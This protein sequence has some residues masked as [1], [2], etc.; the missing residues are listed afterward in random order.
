MP[1]RTLPPQLINQI[2]AGEVVERPASAVKELVENALDAHATRVEVDVE[3]GG[4]RL[5]RIRDD[6]TGIPRDELPL[7]LSRHATSKIS[8][9]DELERVATLGFRG[10]AL[11]SISSISRLLLTSRTRGDE[12][13]WQVA[14]DGSETG[15]DLRP[16]AHPEGTTIEVRD[17]FYNTPARRKF[18]R[19][20]KT[21][22]QHIETLIK[23]LALARFTVGFALTHN[24]RSVL[25]IRP[26][27]HQTDIDDRLSAL[28]GE[29]FLEQSMPVEFNAAGLRLSGWVGLPTY[30]RSQAD[31]QYFYVNGRLVRDKLVSVAI[32]QAY[33]D[34]LYH[35]RQP[36]YVLYL[37]LDP[38][39]VD[40]NAHPTKM[41]VRFRETR[42][43][44]DFLFSGLHRTLGGAKAGLALAVSEIPIMGEAGPAS[45]PMADSSQP[46]A[47]GPARGRPA[48]GYRQ[49][50]L[51]LNVAELMK[52]YD[53]LYAPSAAASTQAAIASTTDVPVTD[54][55][56]GV[57]PPLGYALAH[58]HGAFILAESSHGLIIVD[59]HAAH[60]RITYE[61]L[62]RQQQ[63][64]PVPSQLLL[65]PMRLKVSEAEAELAEESAETLA[66]LGIDIGRIS[67]DTLVV[68]SLPVLLCQSNAEPLLRDVLADISQQGHSRR[69]EE[70]LNQIL[71]TMACHGAVRAHRKL[72]MPEMNGLLRELEVTER[73][74]QCNHGRP[75]WVALSLT[76]LNALFL[77]G[78]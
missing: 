78:R 35:G 8:S 47:A 33:Q 34:V 53:G 55:P 32:R 26:A 49:P 75:T 40:V 18:L 46:A 20:E 42:V 41:E 37:E 23:R 51:P 5:L 59:A 9:L 61:K 50:Q 27:L 38:S 28:L 19:S 70:R 73:S 58:L 6:G 11:P 3:Q 36:V 52:A 67:P 56:E 77:R 22:F 64:G 63:S 69:I 16:A 39:L 71:A 7:A 65:L 4:L 60:E 25:N 30:S 44:H 57:T 74:G 54:G 66:G 48:T 68:R 12:H 24:Q 43:V 29:D 62:K 17:I 13:G 31:M 15:F 1:I 21:E 72:T 45:D 14:A 2:A 76:E 10:E